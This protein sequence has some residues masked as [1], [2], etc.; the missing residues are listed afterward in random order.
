MRRRWLAL[1]VALAVFLTLAAALYAAQTIIDTNDGSVAE[2]QSQAIPIFQTDPQGDTPVGSDDLVQVAVVSAHIEQAAG[3]VPGLAFRAQV[4]FPP[5][6]SQPARAVV[7][8]LDCDRNGLDNERQDRW[9]VYN[10]TGPKT[11]DVTLYTGDQYYGL[12]PS[13]VFPKFL[14]Q[15]VLNELEWAIPISELPIR[16]DEP[17]EL[18]K[19]VDCKH[20]VNIRIATMQFVTPTGFIVLDTLTPP[21]GWDISTGKP[22]SA[23]LSISK[24]ADAPDDVRLDW[25]ATGQSPEYVVRRSASSPYDGYLELARVNSPGLTDSGAAVDGEPFYFY[26][27]Q[28]TTG[29]TAVDPSNTVG[30]AKFWLTPADPPGF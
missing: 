10:T 21:L 14:G 28:G 17:P 1:L 18:G 23:T 29:A 16:G 6:A 11:D 25:N 26:Q 22:L 27:V 4:A 24:P 2:W 8:M 30:I 5:A 7:A 15:R 20:Q 13:A 9:V 12:V 3:D 19:V